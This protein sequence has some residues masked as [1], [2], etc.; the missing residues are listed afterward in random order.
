MNAV[1][2]VGVRLVEGDFKKTHKERGCEHG[3]SERNFCPDCGKPTWVD[4]KESLDDVAISLGADVVRPYRNGKKVVIGKIIGIAGDGTTT[5]R[6]C[7]SFDAEDI[8]TQLREILDPLELWDE[9][10]FGL[11]I[12]ADKNSSATKKPLKDPPYEY[13]EDEDEDFEDDDRGGY[14]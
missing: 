14:E 12:V 4:K 10:S 8:K 2:I 5:T 1:A 13:G 3:N 9:K 7:D 6:K 11:R